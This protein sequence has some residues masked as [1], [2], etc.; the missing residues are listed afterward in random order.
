VTQSEYFAKL[1]RGELTL[2][3]LQ[4]A[5][6]LSRSKKFDREVLKE[7]RSRAMRLVRTVLVAVERWSRSHVVYC[8]TPEH[9]V[10][11]RFVGSELDGEW[12]YLSAAIFISEFGVKV[13]ETS[14]Y[15]EY[16]IY[17]CLLESDKKL[18]EKWMAKSSEDGLRAFLSWLRQKEEE[19]TLRVIDEELYAFLKSVLS[20]QIIAC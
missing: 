2:Q 8:K 9:H 10:F 13:L 15:S 3:E 20:L 1:A 17:K 7:Y 6:K 19:G 16:A 18:L 5:V 14:I 4:R 12:V 11:L